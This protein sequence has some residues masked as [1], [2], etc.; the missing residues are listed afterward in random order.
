MQ[1]WA[2]DIFVQTFTLGTIDIARLRRSVALGTSPK[3]DW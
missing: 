1:Q 3:V 2:H